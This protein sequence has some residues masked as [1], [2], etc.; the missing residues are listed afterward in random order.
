[1]LG[2]AGPEALLDLRHQASTFISYR[3]CV[4]KSRERFDPA[5]RGSTLINVLGHINSVSHGASFKP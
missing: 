5:A 1:M 3:S 4:T 2:T